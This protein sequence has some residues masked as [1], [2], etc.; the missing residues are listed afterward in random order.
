MKLERKHFDAHQ[1]LR[2]TEYNL[3]NAPGLRIVE[4]DATAERPAVF[5]VYL[6]SHELMFTGEHEPTF[7]DAC[8]AL[9]ALAYHQRD[10]RGVLMGVPGRVVSWDGGAHKPAEFTV[11]RPSGTI[12]I[13]SNNVDASWDWL[14]SVAEWVKPTPL[15]A[16]EAVAALA[17]GVKHDDSKPR[18]EL[19]PP[20]ALLA[21][22]E[23]LAYG[24][25]K[26]A[27]DNWRK[28]PEART[29][30]IGAALRHI[31]AHMRGERLDPES[32]QPHLA[33]AVCSI[34]FTLELE[35]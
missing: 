16:G 20:R 30:Y 2:F 23:V 1:G 35:L 15:P 5:E 11:H 21:V 3:R 24:A 12:A 34:L 27:P 6:P 7:E 29:R 19:L 17:S 13:H 8:N 33:H 26:Y 4:W 10:A 25:Q 9:R 28:V 18:P 14:V 32:K 31:L 22:S